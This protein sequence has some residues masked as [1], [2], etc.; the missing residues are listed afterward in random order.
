MSYSLRRRVPYA[1]GFVSSQIIAGLSGA[2]VVD[3]I[4]QRYPVLRDMKE[5][6]MLLKHLPHPRA[7]W[8]ELVTLNGQRAPSIAIAPAEVQFWRIGNIGADLFL[9]LQLDGALWRNLRKR[10]LRMPAAEL[11][12]SHRW[13]RR[14]PFPSSGSGW[15]CIAAAREDPRTV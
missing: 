1:H 14:A 12:D 9:Q 8:E 10:R 11:I 13:A 2:V 4:D 6:V 7:D 5:R 15:R 3:G